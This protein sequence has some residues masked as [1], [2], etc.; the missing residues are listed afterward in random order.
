MSG[1]LST[2]PAAKVCGRVLAAAQE[3]GVHSVGAGAVAMAQIVAIHCTP[4]NLR[5]DGTPNLI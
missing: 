2:V 3:S 1:S 5:T 4:I